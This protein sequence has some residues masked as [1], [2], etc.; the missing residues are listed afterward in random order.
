MMVK[1]TLANMRKHVSVPDV[2]AWSPA[3]GEQCSANPGDYFW[4]SDDDC[5]TDSQGDEMVL[6]FASTDISVLDD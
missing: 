6:A 1:A 5:L 4:M 2:M 3:T